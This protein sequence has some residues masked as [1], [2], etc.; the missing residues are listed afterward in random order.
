MCIHTTQSLRI[1]R[2]HC[3]RYSLLMMMSYQSMEETRKFVCKYCS[4]R[5]PCGKSLGGHI[6]THMMSEYHHHSALAN[7]ERNNNNN[8]A[9]NANAMFKFDG[10]RKRK[11]DLG[12][13][14]NGN[15]NY[16]L[17]ENP[18]KTTRFVHSNATLQ[19]DKF[20]KECGKGFPSLKAL[21]GHMACHSEKDKRRF[22]TEK[23]KLVM[24]SQSDTETSSAPRR[25]KG[26]KFKTLSNNNQP[27]SSS[28]SEVEQEQEEVARCL[29]M[30]SKDSSYKGRF[31]LL[32]ESSDNNSIVITKSPSLETKVT[33]MINGYGKNSMS[34]AYVERKLELEQNKDLKF[35]SAEVGY[36]SDNSDSGYFRYGPKSDVSNDDGFFRNEVK[37]SKVG[38]LNGFDQEYDVESRKVLSRG[39]SRSSE[40]NEFVLE[41]WE[42]YDREDGVAARTFDSKKFKKSNYDDSLGQNL[43]GVSTRKYECLTNEMYNGCSDDSA[44]ESDEN[45]TDTDSYPAPKAHSNRNN[46]SVQKGKKKKKLKSKKSK[47]H[48]CPICNKIFRSGQ[49]LGGHKR[50]HF[51]GGSEENT[52]VIRPSAPPAAVPCLI[53]LNLPAPVDE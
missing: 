18:K 52:L 38:Y 7:E 24:D 12:S 47:A 23:Q 53:D 22:A 32:T 46:L 15:N 17:R 20:C 16:G 45:S 34:S 42:N 3:S 8:N 25:S 11:R 37:S 13:E 27:Q 14:E 4:K 5:F 1:L 29:M 2:F 49:A 39:R 41:D 50:S 51:V 28:V 9:A 31:A 43:G 33:T 10:G 6:R 26:M 19:L 44:Y 48:E 35:K 30:L 36:D 40:F 21:C